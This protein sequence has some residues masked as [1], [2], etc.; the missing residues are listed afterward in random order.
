M[1]DAR[2]ES[3]PSVGDTV[4]TVCASTFTGNAPR[5]S[6]RASERASPSES[7]PLIC[8]SSGKFGSLTTG[9]DWM[10]L[11]R[12]I[13]SWRLGQVSRPWLHWSANAFHDS[14]PL[15]VRVLLTTQPRWGSRSARALPRLKTSPVPPDGPTTHC[16][17]SSTGS[18]SVLGLGWRRRRGRTGHG[19]R[20]RTGHG[21]RGGA[22]RGGRGPARSSGWRS[23]R[24]PRSTW[25]VAH[26]PPRAGRT[27]TGWPP[28]PMPSPPSSSPGRWSPEAVP[29]VVLPGADPGVGSWSRAAGRGAARRGRRRP[30]IRLRRSTGRPGAGSRCRRRRRRRGRR[31]GRGLREGR[32]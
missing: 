19:R 5:L 26:R 3:F 11:S 8:T 6:T 17:P 18:T 21:R 22:G 9:A 4:C 29:A 12:T 2:S 14:F 32:R 24:S 15:P 23:S 30:R 1:T 10:T 25:S 20:G 7:I 31:A 27:R 13:A 28:E 16:P